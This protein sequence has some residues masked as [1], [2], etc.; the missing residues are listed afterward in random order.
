M[1]NKTL[2]LLSVGVLAL[3]FLVS[4]VSAVSLANWN[5]EDSDLVVDS[6]TGTLT[7]SDSRTATYPAGNAPSA[8][9]S[10]ST[11][12]W[13]VADRYVQL[14]I[15]TTGYENIILKMDS[16]VS[17]TGPTSFKIQYSSDGTTF[18]DLAGSTT[19]TVAAFTANPMKTFDFSAVTSID[20]NVNTKL[21]IVVPAGSIGS[22]AVGT[23]VMDHLL[24]EGTALPTL[25]ET[26]ICS[27]DSGVSANDAELEIKDVDI[28]VTS[29]FGDDEKWWPL[30]E[31]EVQI[32]VKNGGD[33][34]VD[35]ISLEWGIADDT[36]TNWV[37]ELDEIKNFNLKHNKDGTYTL[38]FK[39]NEDDLDMDLEDIVGNDYNLVVR[40]TGT[41]DD[42]DAG[43][44]DG[45]SSC[46]ADY[47]KVSVQE[48][49]DFVIVNNV[50]ITDATDTVECG[51]LVHLTA[52]LWNIG[53]E[54]QDD[55]LSV[56]LYNKDLKVEQTLELE[57]LDKF[58]KEEV[59]FDFQV[60]EGMKEQ[61]YPLKF[62]VYNEDKEVYQNDNDD[63]AVTEF[64]M[65]VAGN[66][67]VPQAS[68]SASL[69][70]GGKS[71]RPL[72]VKAIITNPGNETTAYSVSAKGYES[73]A[74]SVDVQPNTLLLDS[75]KAGEVLFTLDV[76]KNA[77]GD[78]LFNIEVYSEGKLVL[79]QPV[80]VT[81]QKS[82]LP[83]G[84]DLLTGLIIAISV[85]LVVIIIVLAVKAGRK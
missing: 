62:T 3:V 39:V 43:S 60:P 34:D 29:G 69:E 15:D 35:D 21:R 22:D 85:V 64:S 28:S 78:N 70:S 51:T 14:S 52:D 77:E 82:L 79:S 24:I 46:A 37:V 68:V 20:N 31:V 59:I 13:N 67:A 16:R 73:W 26:K 19:P 10:M 41:I 30:D 11:V 61:W 56:Q 5:F 9:A 65:K 80:S 50:Q 83:G 63:D 66:C 18:T 72:V 36:L 81:V 57:S 45:V 71:G 74:A 38:T 8:V 55:G 84:N 2:G 33:F 47:K 4:L 75:Q 76:N 44:L 53:T 32:K 40:A 48:E 54:D 6:G 1:K 49:S 25:T 42:N 12:A 7:L 17:A 27:Y 23:F 58:E